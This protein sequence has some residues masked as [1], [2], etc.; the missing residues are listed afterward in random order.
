MH[1]IPA[2][3]EINGRWGEGIVLLFKKVVARATREGRNEGG[4]FATMWKLRL[5]IF[6]RTA[7]IA[8]AHYALR[9]QD[10]DD[11]LHL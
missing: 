9:K 5:S 4:Y 1:F 10:Q 6:A 7:M 3:I 2:A 8:Q 11:M